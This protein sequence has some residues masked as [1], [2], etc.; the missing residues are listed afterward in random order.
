[1]KSSL[2]VGLTTDVNVAISAHIL[3]GYMGFE[4]SK[5]YTNDK[6]YVYVMSQ[7]NT[8]GSA[9]ILVRPLK[10][11]RL[12]VGVD[13]QISRY[14]F[15][16]SGGSIISGL[17]KAYTHEGIGVYSSFSFNYKLNNPHPRPRENR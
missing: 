3:A 16:P 14:F 8:C 2:L 17:Y 13:L 15:Q 12:T 11:E 5:D 9:G 10:N 6:G 7:N 4:S 1:M